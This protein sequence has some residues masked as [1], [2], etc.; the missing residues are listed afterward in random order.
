MAI[1]SETSEESETYRNPTERKDVKKTTTDKSENTTGR[2]KSKKEE[3]LKTYR[4][5]V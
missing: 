2:N 5:G 1:T 4:N 3:R